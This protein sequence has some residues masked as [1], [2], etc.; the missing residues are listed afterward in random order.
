MLAL[1]VAVGAVVLGLALTGVVA[2]I[3]GERFID[4]LKRVFRKLMFVYLGLAAFTLFGIALYNYLYPA[5]KL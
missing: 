2:L 4:A 3:K 1:M 5:D